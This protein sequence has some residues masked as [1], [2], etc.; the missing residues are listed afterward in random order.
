MYP[1]LIGSAHVCDLDVWVLFPEGLH[2]SSQLGIDDL[3]C[4]QTAL[5]LGLHS[6]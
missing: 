6:Y 3:D 2:V 5:R 1:S 4:E